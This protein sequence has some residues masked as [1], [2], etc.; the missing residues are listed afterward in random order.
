VKGRKEERGIKEETPAKDEDHLFFFGPRWSLN[1]TFGTKVVGMLCTIGPSHFMF[2]LVWSCYNL[3][4]VNLDGSQIIII[5]INSKN[6]ILE[7]NR[8]ISL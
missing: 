6:Y 2:V 4:L 8:K 7:L 1:K 3:V 5:I